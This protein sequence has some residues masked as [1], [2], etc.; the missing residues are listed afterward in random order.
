VDTEAAASHPG[1][2][3]GAGRQPRWEP[4]APGGTQGVHT[5]KYSKWPA[6]RG[7]GEGF[8]ERGTKEIAATT[9]TCEQTAMGKRPPGHRGTRAKLPPPT[10]SLHRITE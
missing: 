6:G 2:Q 3:T 8:F 10:A 4:P 9:D 7:H 5:N 1:G